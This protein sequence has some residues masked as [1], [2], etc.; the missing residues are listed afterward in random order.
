M[1]LQTVASSSTMRSLVLGSRIG[2][3]GAGVKANPHLQFPTVPDR[4]LVNTA[5]PVGLSQRA[6]A[7]PGTNSGQAEI[8]PATTL[9]WHDPPFF[10][11]PTGSGIRVSVPLTL[12]EM[13]ECIGVTRE[14][15][16]RALAELRRRRLIDLHGAAPIIT[17]RFALESF[18]Q[19]LHNAMHR[20]VTSAAN[21]A[22]QAGFSGP[23]PRGATAITARRRLN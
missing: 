7:F 8:M 20:E 17:N 22:T 21:R 10:A 18:A 11:H 19:G 13:G 6:A 2:H 15:V 3:L 16:C 9:L 4:L 14:T 23:L 1:F 5:H 12:Q